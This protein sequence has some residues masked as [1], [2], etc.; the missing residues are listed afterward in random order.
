MTG[1]LTAIALAMLMSGFPLGSLLCGRACAPGAI[2]EAPACHEHTDAAQGT[3]TITGI[4]LCDEDG[5]TEPVI[6]Q[7][8]AGRAPAELSILALTAAVTPAAMPRAELRHNAW[9][10]TSPPGPRT[11]EAVLRI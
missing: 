6:V 8:P 10:A 7:S 9:R 1:Y 5:A 3:A 2:S 11:A 4:H